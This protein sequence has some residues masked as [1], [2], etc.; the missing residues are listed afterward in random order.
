VQ[1]E[2]LT[3]S[4]EVAKDLF[5]DLVDFAAKTPFELEGIVQGSKTLLAFGLSAEETK[6]QIRILGDI[7]AVSGKPLQELSR[8]FG[9]ISAEG[10]LTAERL[11]QLND[12]GVT[13]EDGITK[14][15]PEAAGQFR[16]FVRDGKIG[17][18]VVI[19]AFNDMTKEGGRFFNGTIKLSKTASGVWSNLT[20]DTT[21]LVKYLQ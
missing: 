16:K 4:T 10:K 12:A 9:Q 6:K 21:T 7:S 18:D 8:I 13:L 20:D 17:S 1:L 14:Q 11:N 15:I 19:K 5:E 2:V 3:G